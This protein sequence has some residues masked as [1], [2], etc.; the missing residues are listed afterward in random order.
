MNE[1]IIIR[2]LNNK[3]KSINRFTTNS[4]IFQIPKK[5]KEKVKKK[6]NIKQ[7]YVRFVQK[8]PHAHGLHK[9]P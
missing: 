5:K 2:K 4:K 7:R 8:K 9:C 1:E 6:F 3:K